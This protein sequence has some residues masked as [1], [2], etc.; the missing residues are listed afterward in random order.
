MRFGDGIMQHANRA[1]EQLDD[2][3]VI[4]KRFL[5][6][7]TVRRSGWTWEIRRRSKPL[8]V[9]YRG[10]EYATPQDARLGGKK[11]LNEFLADLSRRRLRRAALPRPRS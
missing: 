6:A 10:D 7:S 3:F 1:A 9:K 8:R 11:A 2:Y 4:V 5:L